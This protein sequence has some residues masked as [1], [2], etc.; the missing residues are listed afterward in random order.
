MLFM[1]NNLMYLCN[2]FL[3]DCGLFIF[4][5][6]FVAVLLLLYVLWLNASTSMR[7]HIHR[8]EQGH[9]KAWRVFINRLHDGQ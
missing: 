9:V 1:L 8:I 5:S 7:Q 3:S 6:L 4:H 2:A